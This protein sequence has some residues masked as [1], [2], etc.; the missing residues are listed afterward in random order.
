MPWAPGVHT[1]RLLIPH[2][3]VSD[4]QLLGGNGDFGHWDAYDAKHVL[5]ILGGREQ[6][7]KCTGPRH[8]VPSGALKGKLHATS[9]LS[10]Y[11]P[12]PPGPGNTGFQHGWALAGSR[13]SLSPQ[14]SVPRTCAFRAR[15]RTAAPDTCSSLP[16]PKLL[17]DIFHLKVQHSP[18]DGSKLTRSRPA[19]P[20]TDR[21]RATRSLK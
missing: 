15:A 5:H 12:L 16:S 13:R 21:R 7:D 3:H 4:A 20:L 17:S 6:G 9:L 10:N 18:P 8:T 11:T 2:P 1:Y 14:A 19:P